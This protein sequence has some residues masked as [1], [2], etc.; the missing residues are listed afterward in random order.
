[1]K[2]TIEVYMSECTGEDICD[3]CKHNRVSALKEPCASC[4]ICNWEQITDE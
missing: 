1:M 3:S 4:T 2:K